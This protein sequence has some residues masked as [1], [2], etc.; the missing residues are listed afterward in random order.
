MLVFFS[1]T[2]YTSQESLMDLI[3]III[4]FFHT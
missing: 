2:H 3:N 4:V 1:V